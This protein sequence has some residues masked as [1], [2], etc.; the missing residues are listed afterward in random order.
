M[1]FPT[2]R[3]DW[4]VDPCV[5]YKGL[6]PG[7][8]L[9]PQ[10]SVRQ[11]CHRRIAAAAAADAKEAAAPRCETPPAGVGH[12]DSIAVV[13]VLQAVVLVVCKLLSNISRLSPAHRGLDAQ[14]LSHDI[15]KHDQELMSTT[16]KK[17]D[18][19]YLYAY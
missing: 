18:L 17:Q 5:T 14:K 11:S 16:E 10:L 12:V 15:Q 4:R 1:L 6:A 7:Y 3:G 9:T 13:V 2:S 19:K 8:S